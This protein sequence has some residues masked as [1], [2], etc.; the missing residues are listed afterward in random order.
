MERENKRRKPYF[1]VLMWLL[2]ACISISGITFAWFNFKSST[3]VEPNTGSTISG[4]DLNLLIANTPDGPFE[5]T[6][7]LVL[8][9]NA[10]VLTPVSTGSLDAFYVSAAQNTDGIT[11]L[12]SDVTANIDT[13]LMRGSVYLK[14]ERSGQKT[15]GGSP[16]VKDDSLDVFFMKPL[17]DFGSD[18]QATAALRLGLKITLGGTDTVYIFRLDDMMNVSGAANKVTITS[19]GSVVSSIS[20]GAASFVTDP[21]EDIDNYSAAANGPEDTDPQ[22]G[23]NALCTLSEGQV[24]QVEYWLYLEGCDENCINEVQSKDVA[25]SLG[26]AGT[27]P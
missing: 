3:N 27:K 10:E 5:K 19:P 25:L 13:C 1:L 21:A 14:A 7:E 12:Y 9:S 26:F 20:Q 15:G 18:V 4:G 22:P 23:A 24:A 6:T 16:S 8:S 17:M 2:V 11:I